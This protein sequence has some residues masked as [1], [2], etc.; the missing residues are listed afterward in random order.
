MCIPILSLG[1][2]YS[3]SDEM[4]LLLMRW[5]MMTVMLRMQPATASLSGETKRHENETHPKTQEARCVRGGGRSLCVCGQVLCWVHVTQYSVCSV[6]VSSV[7]CYWFYHEIR[8]FLPLSLF[9]D[10]DYTNVSALV[11]Y[12]GWAITLFQANMDT[13]WST[14]NVKHQNAIRFLNKKLESIYLD[15]DKLINPIYSS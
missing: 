14:S 13:P 2:L 7:G 12:F 9:T 6:C 15:L 10:E 4:M 11:L 1:R 3:D 5:C 8:M